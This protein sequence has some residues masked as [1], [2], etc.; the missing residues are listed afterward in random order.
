[1]K[2]A[3]LVVA[4][5]S[6]MRSQSLALKIIWP[7]YPPHC[8]QENVKTEFKENLHYN[9]KRKEEKRKSKSL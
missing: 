3:R 5:I 7:L 1:M 4:K 8:P 9:G 2:S 6:G